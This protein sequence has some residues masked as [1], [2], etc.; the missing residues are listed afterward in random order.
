MTLQRNGVS[1]LFSLYKSLQPDA[2][3]PDV[4]KVE[5]VYPFCLVVSPRAN[6][7]TVRVVQNSTTSNYFVWLLGKGSIDTAY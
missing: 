5:V 6:M 4:L 1:A 3:Q 2:L 7:L